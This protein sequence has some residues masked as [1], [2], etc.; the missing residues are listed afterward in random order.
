MRRAETIDR[1]SW[2]RCLN[3]IR[4]GDIQESLTAELDQWTD[5][6]VCERVTFTTDEL[7]RIDSQSSPRPTDGLAEALDACDGDIEL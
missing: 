5:G 7:G 3:D 1:E 2:D 6:D 4:N